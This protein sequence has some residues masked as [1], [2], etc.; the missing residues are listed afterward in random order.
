[1]CPKCGVRQKGSSVSGGGDSKWLTLVLL[2]FFLGSLGV[3]RFYIGRT[4]LGIAKLL[5]LGCCGIWSLV[6]FII[7][8]CGKMKDKDGNY[9]TNN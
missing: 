5:T 4:G 2:S 7:A 8:I 9:V 1:L 6:D 3:D